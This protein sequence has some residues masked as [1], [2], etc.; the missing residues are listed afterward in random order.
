MR[1]GSGGQDWTW[2]GKNTLG[3]ELLISTKYSKTYRER[4]LVNNCLINNALTWVSFI[5]SSKYLFTAFVSSVLWE[6][7]QPDNPST[8]EAAAGGTL[9]LMDAQL[10]ALQTNEGT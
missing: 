7:E 6:L 1:R 3:P 8:L 9:V 4:Y 10:T 2:K 5:K